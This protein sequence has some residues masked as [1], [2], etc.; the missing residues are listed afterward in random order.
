MKS[1][2]CQEHGIAITILSCSQPHHKKKVTRILLLMT[3]D[4]TIAL[5]TTA[6]GRS[7][8]RGT[9]LQKIVSFFQPGKYCFS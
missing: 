9:S 5:G 7:L 2:S 4:M 1:G 6:P 8:D 3:A